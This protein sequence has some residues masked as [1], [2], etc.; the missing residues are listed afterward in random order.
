MTLAHPV[1]LLL[2]LV[3]AALAA[4]YVWAQRRRPQ[5]AVRFPELDLLASLVPRRS[6]W[7]RHVP[8]AL[9]LASLV[10]LTVGFAEPVADRQVPRERATVVVALDVS[11]SMMAQDVDPDRITEAKKAAAAF[12]D[13]L[14]DRFQVGLVAFSGT[15]SV[16]VPPTLDHASV[17]RAVQGLELGPGTAIGEAVVASLTALQS[18]SSEDGL[19]TP[20][21]RVVLLSDGANTQGRPVITAVDL[22]RQAKVPVSTIAYGTQ[23]GVVDVEGQR[24]PVPVDGPALARLAD[25]TGGQAYQAESGDQLADVYKDIGSSVGTTTERQPVSDVAVGLGLLAGLAAAVTALLW[26]PRLP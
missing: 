16:V 13:Q 18:V 25:Q 1:R 8:S 9:L 24:I 22:A 19:P 17:D 3:V 6:A 7:R 4:A 2:L 10:A 15:A 5:A 23:D 14:P 11:L 26:S 12:V 21:A 20:P